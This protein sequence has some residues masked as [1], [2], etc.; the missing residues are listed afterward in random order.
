MRNGSSD[1]RGPRAISIDDHRGAMRAATMRSPVNEFS[2]L[3]GQSLISVRLA[4]GNAYSINMYSQGKSVREEER[5]NS[6]RNETRGR[7]I[8]GTSISLPRDLCAEL[9]R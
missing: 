6:V 4:G 2:T 1:K 5:I 8:V 9:R 3:L 7:I